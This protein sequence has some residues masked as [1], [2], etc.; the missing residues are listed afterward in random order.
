MR[1]GEHVGVSNSATFDEKTQ[2][3]VLSR[4]KDNILH[5]ACYECLFSKISAEVVEEYV[6]VDEEETHF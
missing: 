1:I 4:Y 3:E 5:Q 2:E 6:E